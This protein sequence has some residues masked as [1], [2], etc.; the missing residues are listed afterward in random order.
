[1]S[2]SGSHIHIL[3]IEK[4]SISSTAESSY[5]RRVILLWKM[6]EQEIEDGA[7]AV[8]A[9]TVFADKRQMTKYII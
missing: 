9:E 3:D 2:S 5:M 1:M 7:E 8:D 6:T 4:K